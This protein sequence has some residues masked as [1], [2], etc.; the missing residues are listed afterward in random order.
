[1]S[2]LKKYVRGKNNLWLIIHGRQNDHLTIIISQ[3]CWG[4]K[5][6][7][8]IHKVNWAVTWFRRHSSLNLQLENKRAKEQRKQ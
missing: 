1:M 2:E 6:K 3:Q 7:S 4:I 5:L 8:H